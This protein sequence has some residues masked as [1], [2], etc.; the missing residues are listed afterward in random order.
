M[1]TVWRE[2]GTEG[3]GLIMAVANSGIGIAG[4]GESIVRIGV[5]IA[6]NSIRLL[7]TG[8][9]GIY[10][11]DLAGIAIIGIAIVGITTVGIDIY[12][13]LVY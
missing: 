7:D 6:S 10:D 11:T 13:I 8:K 9:I 5:G 12:Y 3:I 4:I 2:K 1:S